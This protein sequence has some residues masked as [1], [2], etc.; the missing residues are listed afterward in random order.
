M[1]RHHVHLTQSRAVAQSVGSRYG[2]VII[3]E[4][5]ARKMHQDGYPFYKT[6]NNVWL[7][8]HVPFSY[9]KTL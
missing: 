2:K 6:A 8:E 7:V 4:I 5:A 9:I 3:L 1:K